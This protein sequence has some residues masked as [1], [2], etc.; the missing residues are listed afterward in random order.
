MADCQ[1]FDCNDPA[2]TPEQAFRMLVRAS[3]DGCAALN[4]LESRVGSTPATEYIDCDNISLTW[5]DLFF[6]LLRAK[7][8]C[9][10]L[11]IIITTP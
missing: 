2:V 4:V 8:G 5:K 9:P 6:L 3:V 1:F 10:A 11:N 7:D